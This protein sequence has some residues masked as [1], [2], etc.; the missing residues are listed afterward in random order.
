M[1][2]SKAQSQMMCCIKNYLKLWWGMEKATLPNANL[3]SGWGTFPGLHRDG[4]GAAAVSAGP[5]DVAELCRHPQPVPVAERAVRLLVEPLHRRLCRVVLRL[6][7]CK[8][9]RH[10]GA[11]NKLNS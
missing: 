5:A 6:C 7:I 11:G 2:V 10:G 8:K 9:T 4:E 1:P 3:Q